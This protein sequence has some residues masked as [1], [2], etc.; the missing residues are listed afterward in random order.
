MLSEA[1]PGALASFMELDKGLFSPGDAVAL[2][3]TRDIFFIA[4]GASKA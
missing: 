1:T 4:D 2:V 3:A